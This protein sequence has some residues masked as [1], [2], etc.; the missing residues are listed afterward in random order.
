MTL[1]TFCTNTK[2]HGGAHYFWWAMCSL[3]HTVLKKRAIFGKLELHENNKR[4]KMGM[5]NHVATIFREWLAQCRNEGVIQEFEQKWNVDHQMINWNG[6]NQ[7]YEEPK[8][9]PMRMAFE[10][11][12]FT[13]S[14]IKN[15]RILFKWT[16]RECVRVCAWALL[17]VAALTQ[18]II[19]KKTLAEITEY[20]SAW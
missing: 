7:V 13:F 6:I 10:G 2:C 14:N 8:K 11:K 20:Y 15:A 1:W 19:Q 3:C 12:C 5:Q 18:R 4:S 9:K 17:F 16:Y